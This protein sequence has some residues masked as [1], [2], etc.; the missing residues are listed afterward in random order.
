M[1]KR[2]TTT[3]LAQVISMDPYRY[4]NH[5]HHYQH[6]ILFI[7][8]DPIRIENEPQSNNNPEYYSSGEEG[9]EGEIASGIPD[10]LCQCQNCPTKEQ[11]GSKILCCKSLEK[12]QMKFATEGMFSQ[13]ILLFPVM[14]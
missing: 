9:Q 12:W 11:L 14:V 2:S 5:I 1:E 4:N 13:I 7:R 3:S 6:T 10:D 8:D